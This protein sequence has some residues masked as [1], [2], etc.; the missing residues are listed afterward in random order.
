MT[1][2]EIMQALVEQLLGGPNDTVQVELITVT[3]GMLDLTQQS[4]MERR[5]VEAAFHDKGLAAYIA[6]LTRA[7]GLIYQGRSLSLRSEDLGW[8]TV[9]FVNDVTGEETGTMVKL[10]T[11]RLA[12]RDWALFAGSVM[13]VPDGVKGSL[14]IQSEVTP[15]TYQLAAD[16]YVFPPTPDM[17]DNE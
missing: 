4:T 6:L 15:E 9:V 16:V 2:V 5:M 11:L 1:Q 8:L 12:S 7:R 3:H 10:H 13:Q 17:S 14:W